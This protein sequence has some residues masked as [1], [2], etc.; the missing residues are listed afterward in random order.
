LPGVVDDCEDSP[1]ARKQAI[2]RSR[3][4]DALIIDFEGNAGKNK[5]ITPA[6]ILGGKYDSAS[7]KLYG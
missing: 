7:R 5:L 3:K 1:E 4:K 6:D 2:A